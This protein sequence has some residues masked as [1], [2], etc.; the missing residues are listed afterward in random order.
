MSEILHQIPGRESEAEQFLG[1]AEELYWK[2]VNRPEL[3]E[4]K[5]TG[6]STKLPSGG[7][8]EDDYDAL[9]IVYWR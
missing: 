8:K 9:I 7:V 6:S 3:D 2:R 4:V 5:G 1:D